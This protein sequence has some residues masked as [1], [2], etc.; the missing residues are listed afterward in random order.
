MDLCEQVT[1]IRPV[2]QSKIVAPIVLLSVLTD[3]TLNT[4]KCVAQHDRTFWK[5][6]D[7]PGQTNKLTWSW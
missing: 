3:S 2:V 7:N 6:V 1:R 4:V 5:N